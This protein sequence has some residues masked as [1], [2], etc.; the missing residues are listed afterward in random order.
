MLASLMMDGEKSISHR[1]IENRG[2]DKAVM[3]GSGRTLS[4]AMIEQHNVIVHG[5]LETGQWSGRG[6][7]PCERHRKAAARHRRHSNAGDKPSTR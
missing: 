6:S 2:G 4:A 1:R 7:L 3:N 5:G